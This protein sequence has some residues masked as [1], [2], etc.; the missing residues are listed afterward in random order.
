MLKFRKLIIWLC[1][2]FNRQELLELI[3]E[4]NLILQDK[5]SDLK[6]RDDFKEKHPNYRDFKVDPLAP[7]E[8]VELSKPAPKL[9]YKELLNQYF[10]EY[11]KPLK[12]VKNTNKNNLAPPQAIRCPHCNASHQ[13][14]YFNDGKKRSQLKCKVCLNTFSIKP[15][16]KKDK[17]KYYCPYCNHALFLWKQ[18]PE[19]SI[20]KCGNRECP[21]RLRELNKLNEDEKKLRMERSSQFKVCYQYRANI[22][23]NLIS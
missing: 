21:H 6:P 13:Y 2:K 7:L 5:Y 1:K 9:N 23:I 4:I 12:P 18:S 15:Q 14:I 3:H 17:S 22:I 19:I 10:K 8:A 16:F 11:G 20:Y